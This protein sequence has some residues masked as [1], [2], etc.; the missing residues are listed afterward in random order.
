MRRGRRCARE[1]DIGTSSETS[2]R[3]NRND[4]HDHRAPKDGHSQKFAG[5][6][7]EAKNSWLRV[8]R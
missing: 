4:A 2:D 3:E 6:Q 1:S 8:N 5:P 7:P